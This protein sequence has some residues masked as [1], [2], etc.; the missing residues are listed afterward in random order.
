MRMKC[1]TEAIGGTGI[2][3]LDVGCAEGLFS[4]ALAQKGC[5]VVGLEG[6]TS[7]VIQAYAD[8]NKVGIKNVVF[9]NVNVDAPL[10]SSLPKFDYIVLLAVWHHMVKRGSL[11]EATDNLRQLWLKCDKGLVFETGLIELSADF[12][13][14]GKDEKWL[15]QYLQDVLNPSEINVLGEFESFDS[16][17]FISKN[18]KSGGEFFRPI[19]LLRK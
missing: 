4:I 5:F 1:V 9:M 18:E 3:V 7:R 8:A 17:A 13:L 12:G 11:A 10:A 14:K 16:S 2:S 15:L 19:F 6:K